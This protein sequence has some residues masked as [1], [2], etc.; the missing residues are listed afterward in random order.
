MIFNFDNVKHLHGKKEEES[1][2]LLDFG[3]TSVFGADDIHMLTML[4]KFFPNAIFE[5]INVKEESHAELISM[6]KEN[7]RI[8]I[9]KGKIK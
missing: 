5:C 4:L 3:N 9:N 7:P 2:I 1:I 6:A 8:K